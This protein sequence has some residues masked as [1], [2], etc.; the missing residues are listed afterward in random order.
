MGLLGSCNRYCTC[1]MNI[2]R[3]AELQVET[4]CTYSYFFLHTYTDTPMNASMRTYWMWQFIHTQWSDHKLNEQQTSMSFCMHMCVCCLGGLLTP[5]LRVEAW[6]I[7]LQMRG[8]REGKPEQACSWLF[9][10][11]PLLFFF[12]HS[13]SLYPHMS[14]RGERGGEPGWKLSAPRVKVFQQKKS[15]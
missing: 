12:I 6:F 5:C 1:F 13:T 8:N 11:L 10:Y 14:H 9:V 15:T 4:R 2:C 3:K 7:R